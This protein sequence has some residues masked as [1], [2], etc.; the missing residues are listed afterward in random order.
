MSLCLLAGCTVKLHLMPAPAIYKD[1]RL[2][3]A[4]RLPA[5]L[6]STRLPVFYAT[7]R[8]PAPPGKAGH[9]TNRAGDGIGAKL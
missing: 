4:L 3:F 9:Y 6:R 8:A 1:E 5:E 7:T 2:D